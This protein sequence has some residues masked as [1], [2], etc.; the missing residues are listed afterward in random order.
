MG[1]RKVT[2]TA[3]DRSPE[4]NIVTWIMMVSMIFAVLTKII[5]NPRATSW[6]MSHDNILMFSAM[7]VAI[8]QSICVTVQTH[9][10]GLGKRMDSLSQDELDV[11]QKA[12]FASQ[13]LYVLALLIAKGTTTYLIATFSYTQLTRTLVRGLG[14]LTTCWGLVA[15]FAVAFQC[16]VPNTWQLLSAGCFNR[17]IFWDVIGAFDMVTDLG[18]AVL[19]MIIMWDVQIAWSRKIPVMC[20]FF[21]RALVMP[22]TA[23]R[24]VFIHNTAD[25]PDVTFAAG[26]SVTIATQITL[27]MAII[28]SC[29]PFL[30]TFMEQ[31][32]S[33]VFTPDVHMAATTAGVYGPGGSYGMESLGPSGKSGGNSAAKSAKSGKKSA[34]GSG[35][36]YQER[37][38]PVGT[39]FATV[40]GNDA[41]RRSSGGSEAMIIRQTTT[42]AV[43]SEQ[44]R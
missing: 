17:P 1:Q 42:F 5:S 22:L 18:L 39:T 16:P 6:M 43:V 40:V 38:I 34:N 29:L 31:I 37:G 3:D 44:A 8:G 15:I 10:G 23:L 24:L 11:Y 28:L 4:I 36:W 2:I 19:P 32:Q 7:I 13:M 14:I 12:G 27:N 26:H 20:A 30:K 25:N 35:R 21:S 33:T 41:D 9:D